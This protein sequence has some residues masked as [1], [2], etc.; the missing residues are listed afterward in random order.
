[1]TSTPS[2]RPAPFTTQ[3]LLPFDPA[4]VYAAFADPARL[5]AWWGP[6]GFT[7]DFEVFEFRPG[8]RWIF[9]MHGPDGTRYPNQNEFLDLLPA[10]RV[11]IR[12]VSAP[13]FVLTVELAARADGTELTWSQAFDEA[14]VAARVK[15]ICVPANEQNLDRLHR[16]LAGEVAG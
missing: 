2:E 13:Q 9:V 7:N 4:T 15:A 16:L 11:V 6:D 10:A 8:G 1:M 3:R 14:E 12:H 5:A